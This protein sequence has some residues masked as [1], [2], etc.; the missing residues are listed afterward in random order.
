MHLIIILLW[1]NLLH[2]PSAAN[3]Q[4][5][6]R[7]KII[8]TNNIESTHLE[9]FLS[10]VICETASTSHDAFG[11]CSSLCMM[12]ID[13]VAMVITLACQLCTYTDVPQVIQINVNESRV[14][15]DV[16]RFEQFVGMYKRIILS[17]IRETKLDFTQSSDLCLLSMFG[18]FANRYFISY[19]LVY[20]GGVRETLL[21][22]SACLKLSKHRSNNGKMLI[23]S[24]PVSHYLKCKEKLRTIFNFWLF[25]KYNTGYC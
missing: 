18:N 25:K 1:S 24:D 8:D 23:F 6:A 7:K 17:T 3:S 22:L 10:H 15:V 9:H 20:K 2:D 21:C 11:E 19:K 14:F 4:C 13:C 12:Q 16:D 5:G